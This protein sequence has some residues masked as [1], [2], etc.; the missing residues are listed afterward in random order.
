MSV[1]DPDQIKSLLDEAYPSVNAACYSMPFTL[2]EGAYIGSV[3]K[4][5]EGSTPEKLPGSTPLRNATF[6]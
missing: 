4:M 1:A 5:E 3:K 2:A 6:L